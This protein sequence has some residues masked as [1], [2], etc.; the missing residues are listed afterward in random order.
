M[1]GRVLIWVEVGDGVCCGDSDDR[2][3]YWGHSGGK[4]WG[5]AKKKKELKCWDEVMNKSNGWITDQREWEEVY[6]REGGHLQGC[7]HREHQ[8]LWWKLYKVLFSSITNRNT[9]NCIKI[10]LFLLL[11]SYR[12]LQDILKTYWQISGSLNGKF[13]HRVF[14][15][16][17]L[18]MNLQL[19]N[20]ACI[21]YDLW[22][23]T[24][25]CLMKQIKHFWIFL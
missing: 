5:R 12:R 2:N 4:T 19:F 25:G 23:I 1:W 14:F 7:N 8:N 21:S 18:N 6:R 24:A 10:I 17:S 9:Q 22:S 11:V 20:T 16:I 13:Y 15:L 3:N